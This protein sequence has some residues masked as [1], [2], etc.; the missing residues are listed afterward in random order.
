MI[1][2]YV[3]VSQHLDVT[4]KEEDK[5]FLT[6]VIP[7]EKEKLLEVSTYHEVPEDKHNMY[8][9]HSLLCFICTFVSEF[10]CRARK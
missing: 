5:S 8:F 2:T 1:L 10:L 9:D 7:H 3:V 4:P 6:F